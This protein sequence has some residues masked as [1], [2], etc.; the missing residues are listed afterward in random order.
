MDGTLNMIH[1]IF[2]LPFDEQALLEAHSLLHWRT[3]LTFPMMACA[4][5]LTQAEK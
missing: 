4:F 1:N 3:S 5:L 2:K